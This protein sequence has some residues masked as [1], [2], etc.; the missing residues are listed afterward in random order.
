MFRKFISALFSFKGLYVAFVIAVLFYGQ[1]R[2]LFNLTP[3]HIAIATMMITCVMQGVPFPFGRIIRVY[4]VF[5][6]CFILSATITDFLS[7]VL[8]TYYIA[9]FVGIWA[10]KILITKYNAGKL[11]LFTIIALGLLNAIVTIGQTLGLSFTDQLISSLY[12][13]LPEGYLDQIEKDDSED[14][15]LLLTRPGL[16][17]SAVYNGY[18]HLTTGVASL[19]LIAR[20]FQ[21]LRLVPW[22]VITLGCI[23]VQERAPIAVLTVLS[24]L[25]FYKSISSKKNIYYLFIIFFVF[26]VHFITGFIASALPVTT[27]DTTMVRP[28]S[29]AIID[30]DESATGMQT[31]Y[32]R[33]SS[34]TKESRLAN[35][36]LDDTGRN[37]IYDNTTDY[38]MDHPFIGGYHRL[39]RIYGHAPHNLFLNAFIYGG[40]VGGFAILLILFWQSKLLWRVLR[41]KII[42]INSVCYFAGL[43]YLAFTL[44]SLLHNKSIVTGDEFL[45]MLWAAFF[46]EYY[47]K[48]RQLQSK[49]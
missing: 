26:C 1:V 13:K 5:I 16:F 38:L 47:K 40:L 10:T 23:C 27:F 7:D 42:E 43:S 41:R 25:A 36:G 48:N 46:Y 28:N 12:L 45:W 29:I 44:N 6:F 14:L 11:F 34:I 30:N 24:A 17:N 49:N 35:I 33:M 31:V 32:S 21:P 15:A 22:I 18:F 39:K 20:K 37:E 3:R 9:A 19:M 2:L 8:I 4:F